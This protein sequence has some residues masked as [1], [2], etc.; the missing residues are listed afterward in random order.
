MINEVS[1]EYAKSL[2]ELHNSIENKIETYNHLEVIAKVLEDEDVMNVLV[3][4]LIGKNDKKEI[5]KNAFQEQLNEILLHFLYVLIDNNRIDEI[6]NIKDDFYDLLNNEQKIIE[7][8]VEANHELPSNE[9]KDLTKKLENKYQKKVILK[10]SINNK[11]IGG[12]KLTIKNE[13]YDASVNN[14]LN[15]LV[16]ELKG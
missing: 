11:I 10:P 14:Y 1:F 9:L 6:K 3:H 2:F 12:I 7:V 15:D 8:I 5:I 4:P 13:I 16:K